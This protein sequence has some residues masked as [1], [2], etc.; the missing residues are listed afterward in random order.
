[1]APVLCGVF[2][3]NELISYNSS[4]FE[5]G[6]DDA[7]Q[8]LRE[9]PSLAA[10]L[11]GRTLSSDPEV[12]LLEDDGGES[13]TSLDIPEKDVDLLE[14]LGEPSAA[15]KRKGNQRVPNCCL[16]KVCSSISL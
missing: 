5:L 9:E 6:D 2:P 16:G 11:K 10:E 13:S 3:G 1:M 14:L 8:F 4:L 7:H 12:N 15:K